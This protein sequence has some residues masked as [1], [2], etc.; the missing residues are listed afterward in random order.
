MKF[1]VTGSSGLIGSQVIQDIS[2]Q[3]HEVYSCY[4][5]DKPLFG[6]PINLD[7]DNQDKIIQ[8]IQEI[9]PDIIIHLAA[10]TNVDLCEQEK[11]LALKINVEATE[12]LAKQAVQQNIFFIYVSTD[13]VFD[14][15]SGMKKE[16]DLPNPL[17]FYGKSKLDGESILHKL[18][19]N[20]C[21]IRTST[22]FHIN[23]KKSNFLLWIKENLKSN[24][25]I[26]IIT[27]QY[28]SPTFVPNLSKMIIEV[29][30]KQITG[31]IH[32]AGATRLSRYDFAVLIANK[33]NLDKS[34][35]KLTKLHKM[36]WISPRPQDS[37]LD[38][39]KA[40]KILDEKPQTIYQSLE[41][42]I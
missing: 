20:F 39:S 22:P 15:L 35:L 23:S 24:N 27:D 25:E 26:S 14:G 18:K 41:L 8:T 17:G 11:E 7:L 16:T 4:H 40:T 5:N 38:V 13:Y 33:L 3:D 32:L 2:S 42:F 9:K 36:N 29:A 28:T 30:L 21:I 10:I 34:L 1:L 31:I 12:I 37:S 6:I 19:L